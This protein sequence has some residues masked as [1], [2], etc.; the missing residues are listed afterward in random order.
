[1]T[2]AIALPRL[3]TAAAFRDAARDALA[4]GH[5]PETLSWARG[6]VAADLF[7]GGD[8]T[9]EAPRTLTL[10]KGALSE[11]GHALIHS[12]PERFAR[13]Y[14]VLWRIAG[15]DLRWGD[16][17]DRAMRGVLEG[18]KAV[19]RDIHKMHAFLRFREVEGTPERRRFTAW[20]EPDHPILE[21]TAPFFAR[22]F[23][24][25]DW[26][27]ATPDLTADSMG[28]RVTFRE[29]G[30]RDAA[31]DETE[32]LWR[33]YYASIFNPAR[34]KVKAM[35]AEMPQKY[36]K[37]MPEAALIPGLIRDA[38]ARA[39]AM[40][41]A[42]PTQPPARLAAI[43]RGLD[44][45]DTPPPAD[46]LEAAERMAE[47]CK[48]C[49]LHAPATQVVWGEGPRDARL[50]L[51]GEQPGDQEDLAGRPFVGPAGTLLREAAGKAGL[52]LDTAYLTNAV[53][54]FKFTPRGKRRI[55]Q[56]PNT[57]EVQQCRWWLEQERDL[58]RPDLIVALGATAIGTLT[59]DGKGVTK[60]R[61]QVEEDDK[62]T[63]V[64]LTVH[65]SYLLRL[66]DPALKAA[67]YDRFV[68]D[69]EAVRDRLAA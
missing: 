31:E 20:F 38:Q 30:P 29:T 67:E 66:P 59:G 39:E 61:G 16:R 56:R 22:R 32:E 68:A 57:G 45:D 46:D 23:G 10:P 48:R 3:G 43:Q 18:A 33:T 12:D 17:N 52:D 40:V 60:R 55:H 63:P 26:T 37:N 1:M 13:A 28:G 35:Q 50:M 36:W 41:A 27:I 58:L 42:Q 24:D 25:M 21:A 49:P 4:Q 19:R 7:G 53:K 54:H 9:S 65:P 15:R 5:R 6:D 51:V 34:L 44:M 2:R 47:G 62:G 64:F 69:L 11:L 8:A 14:D